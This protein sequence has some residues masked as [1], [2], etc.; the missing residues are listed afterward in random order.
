[1][2]DKGVCPETKWVEGSNYVNVNF[3][4]GERTGRIIMIGALD[5]LVEGAAGRAMQN[6]NLLFELLESEGLE[7]VLCFP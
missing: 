7:L 5:N 1:M 2:L 6:M 4:I 3:V